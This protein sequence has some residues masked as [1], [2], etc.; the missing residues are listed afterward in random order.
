MA[1]HFLIEDARKRLTV[2]RDLCGDVI[3]HER[4]VRAVEL[5]VGGILQNA[6]ALGGQRVLQTRA[7][8]RAAQEDFLRV[9]R[10]IQ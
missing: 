6:R 8:F 1:C 3:Q 7:H 5:G 2:L 9:I 10:Q 4:R